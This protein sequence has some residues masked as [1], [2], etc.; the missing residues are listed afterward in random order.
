METRTK[1]FTLA[2]RRIAIFGLLLRALVWPASALT[3]NLTYDS[4][5]VG[6]PAGFFTAFQ[7]AI[8]FY[9]SNYNDP[10][11]INLQVGWG[12][13][14]GGNLNPGNLGQSS[15]FQPGLKTYAQIRAALVA[16]AKS[17]DDAQAV[18]HLPATDPTGGATFVMSNAEAKALGLLAANATG[19]DGYVGFNNTASYTFDPANRAVA[20]KYDFIGLA[21]HE[22]TEIMGRYGLGQ[23]GASS[24]RYSPIDLFRYLSAGNLDLVPT[25]G[26]YFSIDGGT[27]VINTFNGTGGGDLSDWAG[28]TFDSYNNSLS[29]GHKLDISAGDITEMDAIGW[30]LAVPSPGLLL[31]RT[32]SNSLILT[33]TSLSTRFTIQ[34]NSTLTTTNWV[35]A[36]YAI[37]TTNGTNYSATIPGPLTGRLF[38]RL[39]E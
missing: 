3:F 19:L 35:A 36:N 14:N 9:Q 17:A 2:A 13:I 6:A 39:K 11:T 30:D 32:G 15:T 26:A 21:S 5:T 7:Y 22:I 16:D 37:T 25:N 12:K 27:T 33:W 18:A 38:F 1:T 34:T 23:N 29:S 24:G 8:N 31:K 10:V 4:S 28:L 20:G